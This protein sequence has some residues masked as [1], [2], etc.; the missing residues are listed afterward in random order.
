MDLL[1]FTRNSL[2][3][4]LCYPLYTKIKEKKG[5]KAKQQQHGTHGE[6]LRNPYSVPAVKRTTITIVR[7]ISYA[8]NQEVSNSKEAK[9]SFRFPSG[10][11]ECGKKEAK[12][13]C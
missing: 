3:C 11:T 1:S 10:K 9:N 7:N 6:S 5:F 12:R 13:K 2:S 8:T 4:Q